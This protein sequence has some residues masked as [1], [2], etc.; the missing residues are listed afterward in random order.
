MLVIGAILVALAVLFVGSLGQFFP[1]N[2]LIAALMGLGLLW[3]GFAAVRAAARRPPETDRTA[4]EDVV[5]LDVF[6]CC[7][8]CG[9]ELRV[10]RVG[11]LQVPRHCGE[12][13]RVEQRPSALSGP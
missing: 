11:E 5:D 12:T 10:E 8:E 3:A 6:F 1:G 4:A 9:T 13:M 2:R 7:D